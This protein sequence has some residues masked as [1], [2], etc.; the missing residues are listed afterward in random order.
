MGQGPSIRTIVY[1]DGFNLFGGALKRAPVGYRWLDLD[2]MA[3]AVLKAGH[4]IKTVHYFTALIRPDGANDPS[5]DR[6]KLYIKALQRYI[7]HLV[8][9]YGH[10]T[11]HRCRAR[12]T[13]PALGT[14]VEYWKAEEKG[15]DVNLASRLV[16][17][18]FEDRYDCA[19]LVCND[20]DMAEAARVAREEAGKLVGVIAPIYHP[21]PQ[22]ARRRVSAEL[23]RNV[24]FVRELRLATIRRCQLPSPIPGTRL[25]KP[26]HW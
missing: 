14:L 12:P 7:P 24:T 13:D 21:S 17:D 3:R 23:R 2:A 18:A 1:V 15:S 5:P 8:T 6:Q 20:G 22:R 9:H 16:A 26:P 19:V 10:F 25:H 4:D 11:V